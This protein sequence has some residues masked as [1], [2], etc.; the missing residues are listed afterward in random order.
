MTAR[1]VI[2]AGPGLN[3]FSIN[4]ERLLIGTIG[5]LSA[6][7]CVRE[8]ILR[9]AGSDRRFEPAA[10]VLG[11]LSQRWMRWLPDEPTDSLERAV[12]RISGTPMV[13]RVERARDLGETMV[14]AHASCVAELGEDVIVMIDERAGALIAHAEAQRLRRLREQGHHVGTISLISTITVLCKAA[15]TEHIPDRDQMR[16]IYQRMRGLDDG[17][18]PINKTPLLDKSLWNRTGGG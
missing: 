10:T 11:K 13:E 6:P 17:L 8:E 1:P 3:F 14:V 16:Q 2:D 5:P 7:E 18:V 4:Q 12:R 15:G 9:K